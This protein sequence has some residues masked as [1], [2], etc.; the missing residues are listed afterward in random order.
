GTLLPMDQD[1]FTKYYFSMLAKR[2]ITKNGYDKD[3]FVKSIWAGLANMVKNDGTVP[4]EERWWQSYTSIFGADARNDEG[5]F[6]DF[7]TNEFNTAKEACGYDERAAL[8]VKTVKEKGFMAILATNPVFP[9]VATENRMKWAGLDKNDF[10]LFTT[11][12]DYSYCK[13]NLEYY[14]QIME[15]T[16]LKPEECVMVGNDVS[17]DMIA[18]KLGMKVF[19]LKDCLINKENKDISAYPQGSFDELIVF[20]KSL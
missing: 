10:E 18:E 19:L 16:G 14:L 9:K 8:A 3:T 4:N 5:D 17:E 13:P 11:Y 2:L 15:K 6:V 7:Y 1:I 20:I 12:E